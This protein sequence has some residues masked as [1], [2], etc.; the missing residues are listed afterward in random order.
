MESWEL[1][2]RKE[3]IYFKEPHESIPKV[4]QLFEGKGV[5]KVLDVCCGTG[6]H[7]V[8]LAK[9]GFEV[10]GFDA[11]PTAIRLAKEWLDSEGLDADLVVHNMND[12]FPY[13][14][15]TFDAVIGINAIHHTT[16]EGVR[17]V[18]SEIR[19]VLKPKG[20]VFIDVPLTRK[21]TERAEQLEE[22]KYE[23]IDD[24]TYMPLNGMEKGLPHFYFMDRETV[25]RFFKGF[26]IKEMWQV[27][28]G[29]Y[30]ILAVKAEK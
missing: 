14:D 4:A 15:A 25:E 28:S 20:T 11:S 29:H 10:C 26:D 16:T 19:R 3:G 18:I 8:Y 21:A 1:I 17:K 6:R 22:T 9:L 27:S 23:K 24:H 5:K 30:A 2:F 13:R 12:R 7:E